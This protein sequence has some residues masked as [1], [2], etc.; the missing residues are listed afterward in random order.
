M[1]YKIS[2]KK[3]TDIDTLEFAKNTHLGSL[4]SDVDE[5]DINKIAEVDV[6]KLETVPVDLNK[7]SDVVK[8]QVVQKY[9][10][11]DVFTSKLVKITEYGNKITEMQ[12]R[13]PS[14]TGLATTDGF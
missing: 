8:K 7:F 6:S 13:I 3:E 9:V 14:I 12:G 11:D 4:K 10:Y 5:L 1:C 2:L